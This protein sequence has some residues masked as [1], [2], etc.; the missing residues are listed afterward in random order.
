MAEMLNDPIKQKRKNDLL[1]FVVIVA[2]LL[3]NGF[4]AYK[5]YTVRKEKVYVEVQL[6]E[7]ATEKD[8]LERELTEMLGQYESLETNNS[9]LTSELEAEKQKIRDM[10]EEIKGLKNANA[11]QISQYKKELNTLRD[12]MKGY[13][14]QIDSLNT[15][16][17]LLTEENIKV[18]GDFEKVKTEKEDL[19]SENQDLNSKVD[20]GSALRAININPLPVNEKGKE[21]TKTKKVSKI[22]VCFALGENSIAK[23]GS[24]W[25]YIRIARP[26]KLVLTNPDGDMFSF[27]GE[28]IMYSARREVDY[29]NKDVDLCIYWTNDGQL[30]DG[31]YTVDVFS[32]GKHIGTSS[33]ALK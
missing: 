28:M 27:N 9:K 2:L 25:V 32:D 3:S 16:N 24:R 33:F 19:E 21:V 7:T 5:F 12:I 29:Q 4:F 6:N 11:W 8:D 26:D 23:S 20:L 14:V 22:R 15:R 1:Y 10:I 18:K 13:I 31:V 30:I 17:K